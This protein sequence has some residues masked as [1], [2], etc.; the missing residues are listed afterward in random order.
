MPAPQGREWLL[1]SCAAQGCSHTTS[2]LCRS[3]P[4]DHDVFK[5]ENASYHYLPASSFIHDDP[6]ENFLLLSAKIQ[7]PLNCTAQVLPHSTKY[8]HPSQTHCWARPVCPSAQPQRTAQH[9]RWV[10]HSPQQSQHV[11]C[12]QMTQHPYR[13][14]SCPLRICIT[15]ECYLLLHSSISLHGISLRPPT[16]AASA[17]GRLW[18]KILDNCNFSCLLFLLVLKLY[19]FLPSLRNKTSRTACTTERTSKPI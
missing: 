4:Q 8:Q 15:Q 18:I 11:S 6:L 3:K 16:L 13:H 9:V 17:L 12:R 2:K 5:L 1:S 7:L 10:T 19:Y 14:R